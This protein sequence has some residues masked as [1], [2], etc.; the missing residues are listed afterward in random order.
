MR[1]DRGRVKA[2]AGWWAVNSCG[3]VVAMHNAGGVC[4]LGGTD[5]GSVGV[6]VDPVA[7]FAVDLVF[8]GACRICENNPLLLKLTEV[9]LLL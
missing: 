6:S 8:A 7:R 5:L 1:L 3:A 4:R 2:L 9:P